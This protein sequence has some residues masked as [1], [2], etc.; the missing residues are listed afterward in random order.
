[1]R[2]FK[3]NAA[4]EVIETADDY[5][6]IPG[7]TEG[8]STIWARQPVGEYR[9]GC[10][11]T[12]GPGWLNRNDISAHPAPLLF[13]QQ[14]A[15]SVSKFTGAEWLPVDQ[16]PEVSPRYDVMAC[17][18]VGDEASRGFNGD[19]YPVGKIVAISPAPLR[20]VITVD[21]PRGKMRF[22]RRG[23]SAG[24]VQAGGTWGLVAGV[25]NDWNRE[26]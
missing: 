22:Y 8:D 3:I 12:Y 11:W 26:F 17:P 10:D 16:G 13:A 1:M 15:A 9:E 20:K 18:K 6:A 19:Y 5:R 14:I 7:A 25:R 4:L 23:Q 2:Y 24:W 21:G